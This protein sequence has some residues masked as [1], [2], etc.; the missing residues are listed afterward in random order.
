MEIEPTETD[1]LYRTLTSAIIPRPIGW[2]STCSDEGVPN[3]A[4]YS[5]FNGVNSNNPP[6]LMFSGKQSTDGS[7]K[8][9][10]TNVLETGEFVYNL[11]TEDLLEA[12]DKTSDEL[13]PDEDEFTHVG[14]EPTPSTTVDAPRVGEAKMNVECRL[15]ETVPVGDH[16]VVFGQVT[17]VHVDDSVV[18]DGKV[19]VRKIDAVGRLTGTYY[20]KMSPVRVAKDQS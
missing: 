5:F 10:V 20:T 2:I 13:P 19:D 17:Y 7:H 18:T 11:V 1:A 8:D 9:T 16:V 14:L 4:P 12:M 15:Y 6:V 3:L